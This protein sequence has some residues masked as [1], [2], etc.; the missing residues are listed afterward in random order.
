VF[1]ITPES[2]LA[3]GMSGCSP[4]PLYVVACVC[5]QLFNCPLCSPKS[6]VA[7]GMSGVL[8]R[9]GD[10]CNPSR[11]AQIFILFLPCLVQSCLWSLQTKL[12]AL[13]KKFNTL[14]ASP[15]GISFPVQDAIERSFYFRE[16]GLYTRDERCFVYQA[17]FLS[18]IP[19]GPAGRRYGGDQLSVIH[20]NHSAV[21]A[22]NGDG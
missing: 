6:L 5:A 16:S 15:N 14:E 21:P 13:V 20:G 11:S 17:R 18:W 7:A 1:R 2:A 22:D 8:S 4:D 12:D 9:R 10:V 3:A 19:L